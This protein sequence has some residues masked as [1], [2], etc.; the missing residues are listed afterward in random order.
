MSPK[1]RGHG[2]GGLFKRADG[3]WIGSVEVPSTDG[4]RRQKR[5][6][7]KD[8]NTALHKLRA[9]KAEIAAGHIP[10]TGNTTVS[11]WLEHWHETVHSP[12][13][14]PGSS[15]SSGKT[16]RLYID[17]TIGS[18]R[19]D[20]LT[21][22]DVRG[23]HRTLQAEKPDPKDPKKTVPGSTRNAQK[24]HQVLQQALK[25]AVNEGL[26]V[27]NVAAAVNKPRHVKQPREAFTF[28][29]AHH[30]IATAFSHCDETWGV[31]YATG[32]YTGGRQGEV[33]GLEWSRVDLE[34][35][36]VDYSWQLQELQKTHGCGES[37]DGKFP[38][39]LIRPS[40][41]PQTKW[42][43]PPGFE[44]RLV[45]G[46]LVLTR[47]KTTSG[48]RVVDLAPRLLK[49][50]RVLRE[51]DGS[52]PHGLV[53]HHRDGTPLAP[54]QDRRQWA[55]LLQTAQLPHQPLHTMRDSTATL[56]MHAGIDT[57]VI[58]DMLGHSDVVTTRGYQHTD[59]TLRR[60]AVQALDP[61]MG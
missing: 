2:D 36:L 3:L 55:R 16:I 15:K 40:F 46:S 30:V 28:S 25:D 53:F 21:P 57:L 39:G 50:L 12:N 9:L 11:K 13:V 59:R 7:S 1:R 10:T 37:T 22:E 32:F 5:V 31:R 42:V 38:C 26:L 54:G 45:E 17:P 20:R 58:R 33:L 18:K 49:A 56:L 19:L 24:A 43:F 29:A 44:H 27:R 6:A 23:M 8:R 51:K 48:T 60:Q 61:L 52:N 35:G 34:E 41:C 47:P 14:K 4:K